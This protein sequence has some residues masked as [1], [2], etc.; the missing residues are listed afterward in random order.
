[1][2][3]YRKISQNEI[4]KIFGNRAEK[5]EYLETLYKIKGIEEEIPRTI[6][7]IDEE[8]VKTWDYETSKNII[9]KM[10]RNT[11]KYENSKKSNKYLEKAMQEWEELKLGEYNWPFQPINFDQYIQRINCRDIPEEEKDRIVERDV[12]K[13][14]RI[15]RIN[16]FRNDF[17]EYLI[18]ENSDNVIPT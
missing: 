6:K 4:N 1:M 16:T 14:R 12:V 5:I 10:F 15:K 17:I 18:F 11:S 8:I 13:F 2:K 3:E 7:K 9:R